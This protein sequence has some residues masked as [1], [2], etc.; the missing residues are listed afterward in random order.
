MF[1]LALLSST[2]LST[3]IAGASIAAEAPPS[4]RA[5]DG[6]NGKF[7]VLGGSF[8]NKSWY[9]AGGSVAV[10]LD[11]KFGAQFDAAAGSFAG[12]FVG[13][14]GAHAFWRDPK[15]GLLGVY[16]DTTHWSQYGGVHV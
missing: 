3:L 1:R 15:Q 8:A 16:G 10:P 14:V 2:F 4:T 12:R 6:L 7:E 9:G 5:V 13:G 11:G